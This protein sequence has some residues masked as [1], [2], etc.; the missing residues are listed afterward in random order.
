MATSYLMFPSSS[1]NILVK[2]ADRIECSTIEMR[3]D[4]VGGSVDLVRGILDEPALSKW[5]SEAVR[6][7]PSLLS[8]FDS[9]KS[10]EWEL[11]LLRNL[12][13]RESSLVSNSCQSISSNLS[14]SHIAYLQ[15]L[16]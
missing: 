8:G 6:R 5:L 15:M 4:A 3:S 13:R 16:S 14:T 2:F 9:S 7:K 1:P 11:R 12:W 10:R